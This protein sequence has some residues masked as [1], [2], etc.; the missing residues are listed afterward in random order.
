MDVEIAS[1]GVFDTTTEIQRKQDGTIK[2]TFND[3][4]SGTV[5]YDITSINQQGVVP[6]QR[7]ANDNS[8]LCE[9]LINE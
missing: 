7:V 4:N 9:A 3:C 1:G 6:I 5:E 2:L 8:A